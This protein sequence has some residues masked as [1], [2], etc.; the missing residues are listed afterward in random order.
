MRSAQGIPTFCS[1]GDDGA[2]DGDDNFRLNVDYPASSP[3]AFGCG[4]TKITLND[5][6]TEVAWD[7]AGG[8]ISRIYKVPAWQARPNPVDTHSLPSA[9]ARTCS[10]CQW[11]LCA[12]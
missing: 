9:W 11:L 6:V 4:G 10:A 3:F 5:I 8:G 12:V 7:H 1:S 2:K